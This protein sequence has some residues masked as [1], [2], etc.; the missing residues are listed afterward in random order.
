MSRL[1][2][3]CKPQVPSATGQAVPLLFWE[4]IRGEVAWRQQRLRASVRAQQK[5]PRGRV[6]TAE[7]LSEWTRSTGTGDHA[8]RPS[9]RP[10]VA[11]TGMTRSPRADTKANLRGVLTFGTR[12]EPTAEVDADV[13]WP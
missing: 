10:T 7:G 6:S 13:G 11:P 3:L 2:T 4:W 9:R 12:G 1:A 5:T 8:S